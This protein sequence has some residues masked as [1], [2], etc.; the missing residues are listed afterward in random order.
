LAAVGF[1]GAL[2]APPG[3]GEV[4]TH[5]DAFN[6]D[7]VTTLT[8]MLRGPKGPLPINLLFTTRHA[9]R[10]KTGAPPT[11][12]LDFN[13]PLLAGTLDYKPPHILF[14]LDKKKENERTFTASVEATAAMPN[15][16]TAV[17]LPMDV[18]RLTRFAEATAIEGRVFGVVFELT[19]KQLRAIADFA[20][21]ELRT[22]ED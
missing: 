1:L 22:P 5:K 20:R 19:P 15:G 4:R 21:K 7:T 6:N 11:V 2:Q 18:A 17:G 16:V 3:D 10:A 8:L 13:M 14:L 12:H 9:A